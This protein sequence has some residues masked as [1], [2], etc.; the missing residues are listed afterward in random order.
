MLPGYDLRSRPF[1]SSDRDEP[2]PRKAAL[3]SSIFKRGLRLEAPS[4]RILK[5]IDNDAAPTSYIPFG[6]LRSL[7]LRL[8]DFL[9][10]MEAIPIKSWVFRHS[11][12]LLSA[13]FDRRENC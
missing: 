13:G 9:L 3:I 11:M 4:L 12:I 6:T 8:S 10:S 7:G 1:G 2:S 5:M